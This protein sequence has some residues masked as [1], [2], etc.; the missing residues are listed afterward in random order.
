MFPFQFL[1]MLERV[2]H[3]FEAGRRGKPDELDANIAHLIGAHMLELH[4]K[5]RFDLDVSGDFLSEKERFLVNI[6]GEVSRSLLEIPELKSDIAVLVLEYYNAIHKTSLKNSNFKF[7]FN[8]KPQSEDLALNGQAGDIGSPIAVAYRDA[9]GYLPLERYLA[10]EIR[11]L[12]DRIFGSPDTNSVIKGIIERR[13]DIYDNMDVTNSY[14]TPEILK[15]FRDSSLK[16]LPDYNLVGL[17]ADGKVL[18]NVEYE[19]H[20]PRKI[21]DV[22]VPI[23]HEPT[24]SVEEV[25][26]RLTEIIRSYCNY[27]NS[28]SHLTIDDDVVDIISFNHLGTKNVL[29]GWKADSGN[30]EAKPYRDGFASYGCCEDSFSGEDPSKPSGTGTF[31]ARYIAVQI[32]GNHL[33]DFAR[34]VL[35]YRTGKEEAGLNITTNGTGLLKQTELER[36]IRKNVS[37]G[38]NDAISNFNLRDPALYRKIVLAS[39]FFHNPEFPWNKVDL[40]YRK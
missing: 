35:T 32:V 14:I 13:Y 29:G 40:V 25:R 19:G 34:V 26:K 21:T 22:I 10:V 38:I 27:V 5:S 9:H 23:E 3:S 7:V 31:L 15:A 33:A 4:P 24:L 20:T 6:G 1:K 2:L 11:D 37:L 30:R 36:W 8:F 39:D 18:V 12:I 28:K 16:D 17:K